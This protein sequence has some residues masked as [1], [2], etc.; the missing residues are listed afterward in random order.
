MSVQIQTPNITAQTDRE[1]ISQMQSYLYQMAKQLQWA[2]DTLDSGSMSTGPVTVMTPK[3]E[4]AQ[5][6]DPLA[7]FASL[8]SLIIKSA[9]IVN[10]YYD[11]ISS[12]LEGLYVAQSDFGIYAQETSQEIE[13][14]SE[15]IKQLFTNNQ[16][17]VS[18][19]GGLT[20]NVEGLT[21]NA[22]GLSGR[23]DGLSEDAK[24]VSA[25]VDD[26]YAQSIL[27]NAYIKTGLLFYAEDGTPVYGLEIGQTNTDADGNSAFDKFARFSA[28]RL[29]F[30]D[31]N[32]VEVAY[33]SDYKLYITNAEITGT[34]Y[35]TERFKIYYN[36]GL[37]FQWTG[38][39]S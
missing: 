27:T 3:K 33:I 1:R 30:F 26:L 5:A 14:N 16:T 29:S 9:D 4:K 2:F 17:I 24:K 11:T 35:L 21:T 13:G 38:G 32:D 25:S 31:Q 18:Q 15:G 36:H 8:K 12:R 23:I 34:L 10:A 28:D 37:A 20:T 7:T 39:G 22:E 19:I 6:A